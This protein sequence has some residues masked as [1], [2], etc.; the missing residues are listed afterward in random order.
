MRAIYGREAD[1]MV[2]EEA[3]GEVYERIDSMKEAIEEIISD[4][5]KCAD[6]M[7]KE[8]L[9]DCSDTLESIADDLRGNAD[10]LIDINNLSLAIYGEVG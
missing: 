5:Q 4:L 6:H 1:E 10:E 9:I 2:R 3:Y 8:N 7:D